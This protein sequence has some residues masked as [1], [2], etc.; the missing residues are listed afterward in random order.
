[1][2][3]GVV[4]GLDGFTNGSGAYEKKHTSLYVPKIG[5]SIDVENI[6]TFYLDPPFTCTSR[7]SFKTQSCIKQGCTLIHW[8]PKLQNIDQQR[9]A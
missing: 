4:L 2:D 8:A 6:V 7:C 1:M 3:F 9:L 5:C